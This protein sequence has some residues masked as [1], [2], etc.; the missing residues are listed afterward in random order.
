MYIGLRMQPY[1]VIA[2]LEADNSRL[3]KESIIK[4]EADCA[5]QEFFRGVRL[6]LDPLTTFGVKKVDEKTVSGGLGLDWTFFESEVQKLITRTTTGHA[7]LDLINTL[8]EKATQ[9]Q[10]NG[11]YRRILIKDLRCGVSEK[12]INNVVKKS[13]P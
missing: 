10:W 11:W 1:N 3:A 8:M 2:E 5:N 4:G 6:A 12:T 9:E 7:A 13:H